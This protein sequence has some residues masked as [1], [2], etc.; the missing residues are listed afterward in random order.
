MNAGAPACTAAIFFRACVPFLQTRTYEARTDGGQERFEQL[1][2]PNL[3][4]ESQGS[5][6]DVL[7][8]VLEIVT[9]GVAITSAAFSWGG[10]TGSADGRAHQT[11]IISCL[12]LPCS[13]S[14]GQTSQ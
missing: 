3:L 7:V 6:A 8:G 2:L 13:S 11:R 10:P 4:E 14:L 5:A 1:W 12:S 9:D